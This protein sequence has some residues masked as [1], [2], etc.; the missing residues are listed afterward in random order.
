MWKSAKPVHY[1]ADPSE[2]TWQ[3]TQGTELRDPSGK[4]LGDYYARLVSWYVNG[5]FTDEYGRRHESG[6]HYNINYWE[7]L[8]EVDLEHK[9]SP[10]YY[11]FCYDAIVAAIKRVAPSMKFVGLALAFPGRTPGMFEY[12]LNADNHKPGIPIDLISYHFYVKAEADESPDVQQYTFFDQADGFVTTVRYIEEIQKRL[13]PNV[14]T[15]INEVGSIAADDNAKEP[16]E[17]TVHRLPDSYW[18]LSAATYAYLFG[19]LAELGID[20]I[21]ESQ[22][23]GYPTQFPSVTML[24][25]NTGAPNARFRVLELLK[26]NFPPGDEIVAA[27]SESPYLY[28]LGFIGPNGKHKLLLV[29]KRNRDIRLTVPQ[30]A[31]RVEFV[32]ITTRDGIPR[33]EKLDS[34]TFQLHGYAV[35]VVT[36][37]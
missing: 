36:F 23:L 13:A 7:V 21:G 9:M 33:A 15:D 12:F 20:I 3:Y 19:N 16:A 4:E 34:S 28:A 14:G 22:L 30:P 37:S 27:S 2:V 29:N 11:T 31:K 1:P 8:N 32:D 26:N 24:N 35:A 5:G 6:H 17:R 10:Q 25:W 18:N